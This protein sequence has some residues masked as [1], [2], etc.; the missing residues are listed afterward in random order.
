VRRWFN[1]EPE[2]GGNVRG[3]IWRI[4]REHLARLDSYEDSPELYERKLVKILPV[5]HGSM[6]V[7]AQ[8]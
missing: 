4:S 8:G 5:R 7:W 6:G 1:V 3:G 2:E